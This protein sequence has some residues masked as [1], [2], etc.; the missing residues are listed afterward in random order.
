MAL[1]E[2]GM[3]TM[4]EISCPTCSLA[5]RLFTRPWQPVSSSAEPAIALRKQPQKVCQ[6]SNSDFATFL[7]G[8]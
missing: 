5:G 3:V 8:E 7:A 4:D 1:L 6:S 2:T